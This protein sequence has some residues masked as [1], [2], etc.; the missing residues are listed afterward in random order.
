M[1]I[2]K[3]L[4]LLLP[5][6]LLGMSL[7]FLLPSNLKPWRGTYDPE[8]R[9]LIW[10]LVCIS[11]YIVGYIT[12]RN[13]KKQEDY[14]NLKH[15]NV[16]MMFI[17]IVFGAVI[18]AWPYFYMPYLRGYQSIIWII[19]VLTTLFAVGKIYFLFRKQKTNAILLNVC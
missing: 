5:L 6:L 15:V 17:S 14:G 10:T 4:V 9:Y 12:E 2:L 16:L 1:S 3:R 8:I 11:P 13:M 19:F 18:G 7:A